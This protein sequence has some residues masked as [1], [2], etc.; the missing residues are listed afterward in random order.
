[1]MEKNVLYVCGL[2]P[3][4]REHLKH[5]GE[6]RHCM[7]FDCW[8]EKS[9]VFRLCA[10]TGERLDSERKDCKDWSSSKSIRIFV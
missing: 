9:G 7:H 4:E 2:L 1:M 5:K 6:C 10:K 3:I 8:K